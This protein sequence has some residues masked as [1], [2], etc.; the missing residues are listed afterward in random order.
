MRSEFGR[1]P[2]GRPVEAIRIEADGIRATVLT[3]G[4]SLADLEIETPAGWHRV[5]LGFPDLGSYLAHR[6][7]MGA[8]VGRCANRIAGGFVLDGVRHDLPANGAG[9]V[10]LHGGPDGFDRRL[11]TVESLDADRVS[12]SLVSPDGDEGYPGTVHARA[13]YRLDRR[14]LRLDLEATTDRPTVV[15]LASHAYFDL[16]GSPDVR[17]HTLRIPAERYTPVDGDLLPTG[18]ILALAGTPWDFR[19]PR[20]FREAGST[21][22]NLVLSDSPTAE[23]RLVAEVRGPRTGTVMQLSSTAPGLQVY[24][25]AKLDAG[26]PLTDGRPAARYAGFCLEPQYFP[27]AIN[28]PAF[29]SPILRPGDTFRQRNEYHFPPTG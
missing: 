20:T 27:D 29:A 12:L 11:W 4:A 2:D 26:L 21:D 25:G 1:L 22:L 19:R 3:L 15:S 28:H 8:I 7:F 24:D 13:D 17:D 10:H 16:D 18:E 14:R 6:T 9:R 23:P 5:V